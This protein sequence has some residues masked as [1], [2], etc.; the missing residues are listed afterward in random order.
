M[1]V[2][3][4]AL[5]HRVLLTVIVAGSMSSCSSVAA[6]EPY[7][8]LDQ[9]TIIEPTM[10]DGKPQLSLDDWLHNYKIQV[11]PRVCG[12]AESGFRKLLQEPV[13]DCEQVAED[14]IDR[15]TSG[16]LRKSLPETIATVTDAH[17][18]GSYIGVCVTAAYREKLTVEGRLPAEENPQ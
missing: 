10:V 11:L 15:C 8:P 7:V 9:R 12:N 18:T 5:F 6:P 3:T 4:P 1:K 14:M 2:Y 16:Q 13:E 17:N